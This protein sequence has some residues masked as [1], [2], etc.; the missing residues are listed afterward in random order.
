MRALTI[1]PS[2]PTATSASSSSNPDS[3]R[4][5]PGS[6][7]ALAIRDGSHF[8]YG[9]TG[10]RHVIGRRRLA[11]FRRLIGRRRLSTAAAVGDVALA[12]EPDHALVL[13]SSL[14]H[15]GGPPPLR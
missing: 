12:G 3:L 4:L 15:A 14:L 6:V 1:T 5:A 2:A 8:T 11:G 10:L 13:P 7:N 9:Q